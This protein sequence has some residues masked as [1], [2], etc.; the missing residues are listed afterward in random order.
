MP[1][2]AKARK[3]PIKARRRWAINPRTRVKESAKVYKRAKEKKRIKEISGE[4]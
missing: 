1:K 2:K 4:D 3:R